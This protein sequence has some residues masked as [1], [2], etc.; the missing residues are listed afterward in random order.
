VPTFGDRGRH[1]VSVT[2][3][4]SILYATKLKLN[5]VA[6]VHEQT[7]MTERPLP[8]GEVSANGCG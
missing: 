7:T 6:L 5:S 2:D 4:L 3:P 8:V 1:V